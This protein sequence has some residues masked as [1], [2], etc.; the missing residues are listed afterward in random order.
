MFCFGGN[1]ANESPDLI[2]QK[3]KKITRKA[4]IIFEAEGFFYLTSEVSEDKGGHEE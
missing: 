3:C 1:E 4:K 2:L